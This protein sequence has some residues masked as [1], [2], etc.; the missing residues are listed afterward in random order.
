MQWTFGWHVRRVCRPCCPYTQN[1]GAG[2][3]TRL[4][5]TL[6]VWQND[7][8]AGEKKKKNKLTKKPEKSSVHVWQIIADLDR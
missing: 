4:S 7:D 8:R 1:K 6:I 3:S 5:L 2:L